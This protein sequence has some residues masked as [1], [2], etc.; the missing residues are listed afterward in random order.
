MP[1]FQF[2]TKT[3]E[4]IQIGETK[5]TPVAQAMQFQLPIPGGGFLGLVWNRPV[6]VNVKTIDGQEQSIAVPDVT[7]Q[8]QLMLLGSGLIG[9]LLLWLAFRKRK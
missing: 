9:A 1:L 7:R 8:A 6:A 5:V 4:P 3:G 2:E